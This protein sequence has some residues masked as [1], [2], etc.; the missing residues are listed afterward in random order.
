MY[1]PKYGKRF[2]AP[3]SKT[4]SKDKTIVISSVPIEKKTEPIIPKSPERL[5][6]HISTKNDT[7]SIANGAYERRRYGRYFARFSN[8]STSNSNSTSTSTSTIPIPTPLSLTPTIETVKTVP[9]SEFVTKTELR[10]CLSES[11]HEWRRMIPEFAQEIVKY[12]KLIEE[13]PENPENP[14]NPEYP[15]DGEF[16]PY[17]DSPENK[18]IDSKT[19]LNENGYIH[20]ET[21]LAGRLFSEIILIYPFGSERIALDISENILDMHFK[22]AQDIT[23]TVLGRFTKNEE[24]IYV[25]RITDCFLEGDSSLGSI[26][27]TDLDLPLQVSFEG[28]LL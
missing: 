1:Q 9:H 10:E 28:G 12:I 4:V 24:G 19:V 23:G 5:P 11:L 18:T 13:K 6:L 2:A 15:T 17:F 26:K 21:G 25:I 8:T 27:F 20:L 3:S 22:T 14:E 16:I 7:D